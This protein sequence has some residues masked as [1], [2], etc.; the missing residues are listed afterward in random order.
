MEN[1]TL[2]PFVD[3]MVEVAI[4]FAMKKIFELQEIKP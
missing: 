3:A 4:R 1:Q 2:D